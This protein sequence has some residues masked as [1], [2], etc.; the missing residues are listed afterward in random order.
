LLAHRK[1]AVTMLKRAEEKEIL[2][3]K[4]KVNVLTVED[5]IGLKVQSSSNDPE[6]LHQD[7]ADIELL[8]KNNY[9]DLD[10]NL[11]REYFSLFERKEEF[12]KIIV[13]IDNA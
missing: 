10:L 2:E 1:Y 13:R 5:Q 12:E 4:F 3:G 8:I 9:H 7:M 6:R 11:L